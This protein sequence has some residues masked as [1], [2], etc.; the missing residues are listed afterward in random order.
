M[1]E[2]RRI[3]QF[4]QEKCTGCGECIPACHEGALQIINGKAQLIADHLCDG[5]GDCLKEC[6]YGAIQIIERHADAYD[7][8]AVLEHLTK[9]TP[10]PCLSALDT[11][12]QWPLQLHLVPEKADYFQDAD[13]L[14]SATCASVAC[15]T[16]HQ[17][18]LQNKTVVIACPKLDNTVTYRTKL[19]EI[20]RQ[21]NPASLTIA[22]MT[23]PCCNGLVQITK[24]ALALAD[25]DLPITIVTIDTSGNIL[26]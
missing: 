8:Q 6:P 4:D 10:K 3:I 18:I 7:H 21:N 12:Q 15:P 9:N 20:I 5:L 25:S 24:E 13:L 26:T 19:A 23:V 11:K 1:K 16:Y 14:L 22:K 2:N 17:A